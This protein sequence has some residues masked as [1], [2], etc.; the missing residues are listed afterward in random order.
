MSLVIPDVSEVETL[1]FLTAALLDGLVARLYSNNHTPA[2]A[3]VLVDFTECVFA[4]YADQVLTGWS[5]A[6]ID[7]S[8][9]AFSIAL[10]VGFTPTLLAGSGNIYGWYLTDAGN[11]ILYGAEIFSGAPLTVAQNITLQLSV[12]Y[13][14]KSEF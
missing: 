10:P 14:A 4:G 7:G 12:T 6:A 8:S 5:N 2:A 1:D 13:T 9:H 11:T 3:S